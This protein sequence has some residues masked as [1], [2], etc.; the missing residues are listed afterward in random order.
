MVKTVVRLSIRDFAVPSPLTGSIEG[1]SGFQSSSEVGIE[2]HSQIQE[3]R[4]KTH[5][6][7][8]QSE[9]KI[10]FSFTRDEFEFVIEGRMDGVF[11]ENGKKPRIEEIKSTFSLY[12][13][14]EKLKGDECSHPYTLQLLT[15][16]YFYEKRFG[17]RPELSFFLV[18]SRN[19]ESLELPIPLK[20]E[21]Y[22]AWL[23]KR[24][25]ELV[26][27]ATRAVKRKKRRKKVASQLPFPFE[28]PRRG[29]MEL[30]QA[31]EEGFVK[32]QRMLLQAPTG[33]GKT[34]GVLY[35]TLKES[36]AR[37]RSVIYVTP[38]NS[39]HQV[40]EDAI[41]RFQDQGA[42]LKS[43]T[44]TAKQ[45]LCLKP[46]PLCNP[47]Y[48][49]FAKDYY[50]KLARE[51]IRE[52]IGQKKNLSAKTFK[53]LGEKYEVCP[54]EL[55]LEAVEEA[56]V[57]ICDYNYVFSARSALKRAK[58]LDVDAEGKRN[59]V[60]DEAHNLPGRAMSYYSPEIT[61]FS[62]RR[63]LDEV[64]LLPKRFAREASTLVLECIEVIEKLRP[65]G[66]PESRV[67][68]IESGVFRD[69]E[70]K[71][72]SLL[73]E[74]L[75]SHVEIE[76]RDPILAVNFYWSEFT[77]ML[78]WVSGEE[79]PEFFTLYLKSGGVKIS[80]ADASEML[81][82][83]YS[84]F[85]QV[86]GFSATLK[87]F[88]YYAK[89]SG[90]EGEDLKTAEFASPFDHSRRKILIIPQI[91]TKFQERA[92]NYARIAETIERVS[93]VKRGNQ[94]V[95]F[96]SFDFLKQ[97]E[98]KIKVPDGFR[99]IVQERNTS[100]ASV[101]ETLECLRGEQ[102]VLLFAVQGGVYSEGV[103][104]PGDMAIGVFVVGP[105]LPT[106]D[107]EREKMREYYQKIFSAGF[108]YA[109][110][111]PAMAKAIQSAGRVIRTEAD[112]GV[113]VL[114]DS[115]F[116]DGSYSKSMPTDWFESH[117]N[118]LVSKQILKDL[119]GFWAG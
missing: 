34:V 29:Q 116:L 61:L 10:E 87:P 76:S 94:L 47:R 85:E 49:E 2:I 69:Q 4:R 9:S 14:F 3:L 67:V 57:V 28:T 72:R 5:P 48:C 22:E 100:A 46:E 104:Y 83:T 1:D 50:D 79:R 39:Q 51:K 98:A 18:S 33:L 112:K 101:L 73:T 71:L 17:V 63:F 118:E 36:L 38:K 58:E 110:T 43:L 86:V 42:K 20:T 54:F 105:P 65:E 78:E 7:S 90:L 88:D 114:M 26:S 40:A 106:F 102:P 27:A 108:D 68:Q 113:I 111:Y 96:P 99:F 12:D 119:E 60:I 6:L 64:A 109:Y 70:T 23:E 19:R 82:D 62:L 45:K 80:C 32:K 52:Q 13:L 77:E 11:E 35:P 95:F 103:D 89:L 30:I 16:G 115:R 25:D 91:S 37:G 117:P 74:Y 97:V 21:V 93:A 24:L 66:H 75:E 59:L 92:K 41:E 31:I 107:V 53:A 84:E 44:F 15:Y 55:Q 81:K 56:D 8:Y